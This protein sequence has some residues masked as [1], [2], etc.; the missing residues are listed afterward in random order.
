MFRNFVLRLMSLSHPVQNADGAT[1]LLRQLLDRYGGDTQRALWAYNAGPGNV[2]RHGPVSPP[3]E[4]R[5]YARQV[6]RAGF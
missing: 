5:A 3:P 1:R 6:M 2:P 4:T